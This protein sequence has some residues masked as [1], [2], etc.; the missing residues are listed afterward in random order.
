M[1]FI[2]YRDKRPI[3]EQITEKLQ[4]LIIQGV[5]KP[6]SKLPSVRTLA[7][8]LAINPNTIQR[9][10]AQLEKEGYLYTV[11]GKGNY[12]SPETEWKEDKRKEIF[13]EAEHLVSHAKA[14]GIL[15]AELTNKIVEFYQKV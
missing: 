13:Q 8:E 15:E 2:D 1:I 7:L 11:K 14:I 9:A 10:Y 3:Y 12:V 6:E 4:N 5:L